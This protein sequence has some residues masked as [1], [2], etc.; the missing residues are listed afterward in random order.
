MIE[1]IASGLKRALMALMRVP[2]W[3]SLARSAMALTFISLGLIALLALTGVAAG[4][5]LVNRKPAG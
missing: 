4:I 2:G 5:V 1:R 3:G